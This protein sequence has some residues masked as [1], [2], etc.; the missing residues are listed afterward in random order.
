MRSRAA[1]VVPAP[2]TPPEPVQPAVGP[3]REPEQAEPEPVEPTPPKRLRAK[4]KQPATG[5]AEYH[6]IL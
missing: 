4:A 6:L 2:K 1:P 5:E 3:E